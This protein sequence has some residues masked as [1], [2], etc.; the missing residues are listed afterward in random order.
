M[1]GSSFYQMGNEGLQNPWFPEWNK[2]FW[3]FQYF[4]TQDLRSGI[5]LCA[6][7]WNRAGQTG[8]FDIERKIPL[9]SEETWSVNL[10]VER[11]L[12]RGSS[13]STVDTSC[14]GWYVS[15]CVGG[16][17]GLPS[18]WPFGGIGGWQCWGDVGVSVFSWQHKNSS[19]SCM[20]T[21]W[22]VYYC[23]FSCSCSSI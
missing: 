18:M 22:D 17:E 2:G 14:N 23:R 15:K 7:R 20:A 1:F 9:L 12:K 13:I 21:H 8:L 6:V 4:F 10:R 5:Y 11:D 16:K 3:E 19:I